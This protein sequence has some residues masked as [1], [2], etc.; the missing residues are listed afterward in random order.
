MKSILI[1]MIFSLLLTAQDAPAPDVTSEVKKPEAAAPA[2]KSSGRIDDVTVTGED[3]LKVKSEKPLLEI[4]MNINE[5]VLPTIDTEKKFLEKSPALFDLKDAVPKMLSSQQVAFPYLLIFVKEPI[6]SFSLKAV[7]FKTAT[8][9][10][11]VTDSKGKTFKKFE[12]K[13][14]PPEIIEWSGRNAANKII[15]V[16]N[17]YSYLINLVDQAGNPRTVIGS[18]FVI[19]QLVHQEND[20]LYVSV[21]RKKIFDVEKEK[22]KIL[23]DGIPILKEMSDYL[24]DNFTLSATVEVYGEEAGVAGEQ[25][26]ILAQYFS[27]TL[28]LPEK[29][30]KYSSFEDTIENHRIDI[31]IK[32]R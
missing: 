32:N 18:P 19:H 26:K 23:E 7:G 1:I 9:E 27:D 14:K 11:I 16:G 28:I 24:K 17:P 12:G 30:I 29:N 4:K 21:T 5:A 20:G 31:K 3:K 22:T 2:K 15:K 25:A 10:L 13:G 8:W 6:A